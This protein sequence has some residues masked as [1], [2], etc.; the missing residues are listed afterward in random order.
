MV[1]GLS[2]L[3]KVQVPHSALWVWPESSWA[4][5]VMGPPCENCHSNKIFLLTYNPRPQEPEAE[6]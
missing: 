3:Q 1:P 2:L 6:G 4:T 5:G